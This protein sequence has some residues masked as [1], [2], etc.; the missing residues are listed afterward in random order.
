MFWVLR[1]F[2]FLI[3]GGLKGYKGSGSRVSRLR[4]AALR[5]VASCVC[6]V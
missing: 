6:G 5:D 2:R 3:L 4:A 1:G